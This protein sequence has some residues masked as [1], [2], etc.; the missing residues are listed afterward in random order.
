MTWNW[1]LRK[2]Q[3]KS[4]LNSWKPKSRAKSRTG[5]T[6][7][8]Q[9]SESSKSPLWRARSKTSTSFKMKKENLT[10]S[11]RSKLTE[12]KKTLIEP[13]TKRRESSRTRCK[14]TS[15]ST[16]PKKNASTKD[17]SAPWKT[18]LPPNKLN[19]RVTFNPSYLVSK[20]S[21]RETTRSRSK[22]SRASNRTWHRG[23]RNDSSRRDR[24]SL[25][26][27][28]RLLSNS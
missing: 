2:K 3:S 4:N 8:W 6:L 28:N 18:R 23:K 22:T 16:R 26:S 20:T 14:K 27:T 19:H 1:P 5:T 9:S 12:W 13:W 7:N 21:L 24:S 10:M 25:L 11:S 17:N 15:Q